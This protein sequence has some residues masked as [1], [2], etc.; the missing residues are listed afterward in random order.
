M[1]FHIF[2]DFFFELFTG[3]S[4]PGQHNAGLDHL[5]AHGI[6]LRRYAAFQHIGQLHDHIFDL[7]GADAVAAALDHI[8]N[9][10]DIPEIAVL[11]LIGHIAGV[12]QPAAEGL[13]GLFGVAVV[14][15]HQA[16][17]MALVHPDA[18]FARGSNGYGMAFGIIN[19]NIVAGHRLAHG[20]QLGRHAHGIAHQHGA[21]GLAEALHDGKPGGLLELA[22]HLGIQR[23][24]R[25]GHMLDAGQVILHDIL[26][27]HH[28]QHGGRRAEG[29]DVVL[30]KHGQ[31]L[32]GMEAV[33]VIDEQRRLAQPLAVQLSPH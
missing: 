33:K 7:K 26:A 29:G 10:A 9:A 18:D 6:R 4:A 23:L 15:L 25:R 1:G 31:D 16:V 30:G 28:A 17:G 27:D 3:L 14:F 22:E 12:V 13:G 32:F 5:T 11:I 2:L 20:T 19:I 8:I 21:L 24:A